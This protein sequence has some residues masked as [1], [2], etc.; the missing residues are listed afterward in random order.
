MNDLWITDTRWIEEEEV[1]GSLLHPLSK[2]YVAQSGTSYEIFEKD[3]RRVS[4]FLQKD[5]PTI[6]GPKDSMSVNVG[7]RVF[8]V[9]LNPVVLELKD[10]FQTM[11]LRDRD[12]QIEIILQ[13]RHPALFA[14][15]CYR[16]SDPIFIVQKAIKGRI[17]E[18]AERTEDRQIDKYTLRHHVESTLYEQT[19]QSL[20]VMLVSVGEFR[21]SLSIH[22]RELRN[23]KDKTEIRVVDAQG[24]EEVKAIHDAGALRSKAKDVVGD[25]YIDELKKRFGRG[26]P[27]QQDMQFLLGTS[28]GGTILPESPR[29]EERK[30]REKNTKRQEEN[31][32]SSSSNNTTAQN[33]QSQLKGRSAHS[34][35]DEWLGVTFRVHHLSDEDQT[36][37]QLSHNTIFR[38]VKVDE[39][40][41]L[42]GSLQEGDLILKIADQP[43]HDVPTLQRII[44]HFM[45]DGGDSLAIRIDRNEQMLDLKANVQ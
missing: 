42:A 18:Y 27:T 1:R 4:L 6:E 40:G 32:K 24:D 26:K 25:I 31:A 29:L 28:Q 12:Y 20:G 2:L 30:R 9:K 43:A 35:R 11:N 17:I 3:G 10:T 37:L 21:L 44:D 41:Q 38:V 34:Y 7:A 13:V 45:D 36:D 23:S 33:G 16:G 14:E 5:L 8:R 19:Y 22:E 15:T 39:K